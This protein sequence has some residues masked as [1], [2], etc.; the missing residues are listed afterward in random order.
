MSREIQKKQGNI[1][2]Q[3]NS[4][5]QSKGRKRVG[6]TD[7]FIRMGAIVIAVLLFNLIFMVQSVEVKGNELADEKEILLWLQE[8]DFSFNSIY[9]WSKYNFAHL[10]YPMGVEGIKI[11][12]KTPWSL[13]VQVEDKAL[14]GG[15]IENNSYAYYDKDGLVL[16][17]TTEPI[18]DIIVFEGLEV[19]I[20]EIYET[21]QVENTDIFYNMLE[22]GSLVKE[23][24]LYPDTMKQDG[25]GVIIVFG[26]IIVQ[27]GDDNYEFKI[28]RISPI[29]QELEGKEGTLNMKNYNTNNDMIIFK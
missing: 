21:L 2:K 16:M 15:V 6:I 17:K 26:G 8:D 29:L 5:N 4:S 3:K 18:P 1:D 10:D 24:S 25:D 13:I 28:S 7:Y 22:V 27:L 12:F 23:Q 14:I 19:E 11:S 20:P 9:L